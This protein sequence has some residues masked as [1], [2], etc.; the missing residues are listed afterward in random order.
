MTRDQSYPAMRWYVVCVTLMERIAALSDDEAVKALAFIVAYE[1][2]L[3]PANEQVDLSA[4]LRE[5]AGDPSLAEYAS[6]AIPSDGD[7]AR[8]ALRLVAENGHFAPDALDE[9]VVLAKR[10]DRSGIEL[11]GILGLVAVTLQTEVKL[12]RSAENKWKFVFHKRPM[13]DSTIAQIIGMLL[14]YPSDRP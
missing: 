11:V 5:A 9:A 12:E 1:Q 8:A 14:K 7:L 4:R 2:L 3:P 13:R 6:P 10:P